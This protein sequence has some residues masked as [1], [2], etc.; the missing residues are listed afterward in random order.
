MPGQSND[1]A[2]LFESR[3]Q[4]ISALSKENAEMLRILQ[5]RSGHDILMMKDPESSET[6][7]GQDAAEDEMKACKARIDAL[8]AQL[9]GIDQQIETAATT[10]D[11]NG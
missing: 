5:L 2:R 8:E 11:Q 6:D 9:A 7:I 1:M 10:E 3:M 4:V